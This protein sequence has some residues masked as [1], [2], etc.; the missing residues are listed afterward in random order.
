MT[1][2]FDGLYWTYRALFTQTNAGG[3]VIKILITVNER[4]LFTFG[5]FLAADYAGDRTL[6][7]YLKHATHTIGRVLFSTGVDNEQVPMWAEGDTAVDSGQV[8]DYTQR[9]LLG[10]GD[11][12]YYELATPVQDEA[13]TMNVH[14]LIRSWPPTV[15]TTG[16][17]G[18]VT[19]TVAYDK[20]I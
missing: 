12:L 7:G 11:F 16:S 18:T 3:G 1:N 19:T 14:A 17:G 4:T 5:S 8:N 20:V 13:I 15:A 6:T 2:D 10:K 9:I